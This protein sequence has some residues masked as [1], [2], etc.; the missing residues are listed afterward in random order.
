VVILIIRDTL[1]GGGHSGHF[2]SKIRNE[3]QEESEDSNST[4]EGEHFK[5]MTLKVY[6]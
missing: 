4:E 1:R 3:Y 6:L 2:Y 5:G